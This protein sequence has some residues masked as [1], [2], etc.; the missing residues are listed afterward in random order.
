MTEHAL[1]PPIRRPLGERPGTGHN[2][3]H[4]DVEPALE[5][6]PEDTVVVDCADGMDGQIQPLTSDAEL[7]A[8]DGTRPHPMTGPIAVRGARPG[9]VLRVEILEVT[10]DT[11]G[12]TCLIPGFGI[13]AD[14][15]PDP[16]LVTWGLHDGYATSGRMPGVRIPAD[17]FVGVIG[18]AP[19]AERLAAWNAR[20]AP[21]AVHAPPGAEGAEPSTGPIAAT[22]A[23][24]IP[25][26]ELG[27]NLDVKL[28][29]AGSV[30]SFPVDVPGA[31]LSLGDV[32]FA[33]GDGEVCGTAIETHGRVRLRVDLIPRERAAYVPRAPLVESSEPARQ[34]GRRHVATLGMAIGPEPEQHREMDLT[35]ATRDALLQMIDWLGAERGLSREQAY[36]LCSAAVELRIGEVVDV[37]SP[38]V[39]AL[40]PL[41]IFVGE[42]PKRT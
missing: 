42:R 10:T 18:V 1:A 40:C 16:Y 13:L 32:H 17:P 26:R 5:V 29:R 25:P 23:R 21:T 15:F 24:T 37:P 6:D 33:Q 11:F 35:V 20:E 2:R 31:N 38:V 27:G 8:F 22:G 30:I 41:D 3:W 9:D 7:A 39:T 19:S 36:V 28:V 12:H 4:P 14:R 34:G